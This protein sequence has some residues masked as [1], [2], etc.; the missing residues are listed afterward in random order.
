MDAGNEIIRF[1]HTADWHLGLTRNSLRNKNGIP[2]EY[3]WIKNS[4]VELVDYVRANGIELVLMCGD[5]LHSSNPSPTVENILAEI[6][7]KL[8]DSGAKVVYLLGNHEIP[9]WGDHPARIYNT[10]NVPNVIIA[11]E[12]AV[13]K[14][15]LDGKI[16]QIA[17]I[18]NDSLRELSFDDALRKILD[19][20]A[21]DLPAILM[22]HIFIDGAKLSGSDISLLPNES[23]I[24]PIAI[25]HL[26]FQYVAL[27]HIHRYQQILSEPPALYSGSLQRVTFAEESETKGFVDVKIISEN[28]NFKTRWHFVPVHS[29]K[30]VTSEIDIR[31][32]EDAEEYVIGR[33]SALPLDGVMLKIKIHRRIDDMKISLPRI[34]KAG[35][36]LGA[37]SVRIE[38]KIDRGKKRTDIDEIKPSGDIAADVKRYI[39][40]QTPHLVDKSE[41]ILKT[42]DEL[43]REIG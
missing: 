11:D 36:E 14:I 10:L 39:E 34:R 43:E 19:E 18:P 41:E 17:T 27:G 1:I 31:G 7:D 30:F 3:D 6:L 22:S 2:L 29:V 5:I 12:I 40:S 16:V 32:I 21:P 4:A 24:S 23:H 37:I 38:D 13:H 35:K 15:N 20:L 26:P 28:A 42:I 33:I 8:S 9:G 25:N